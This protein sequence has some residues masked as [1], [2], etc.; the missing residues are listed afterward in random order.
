MVE[1]A[2]DH[3]VRG[4]HSRIIHAF[5]Q[6]F[7]GAEKRSWERRGYGGVKERRPWP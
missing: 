4:M 6:P 1:D 7:K 5:L 2:E 3:G